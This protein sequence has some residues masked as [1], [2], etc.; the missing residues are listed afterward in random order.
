[1][2][3][4]VAVQLRRA[5]ATAVLAFAGALATSPAV[6]AQAPAGGYGT[7]ARRATA[8]PMP[9]DRP[10]EGRL[11]ASDPRFSDGSHFQ[12]WRVSARVGE[13]LI[14]S[15]HSR[16]FAAFLM[17]LAA[18]G[19]SQQ[20]LQVAMADTASDS[21]QL[22][23]HVRADGDYLLVANT[24]EAG[25][26]GR[27]RMDLRRVELG[28]FDPS[29]RGGEGGVTA[30]RELSFA[31]APLLTLGETRDGEL[32]ARDGMLADSSH[33]NVWRYDGRVG[34]R[35]VIDLASGEF[36]SYLL[37]VRA[38]E[39][40]P[41]IF[42][43]NDDGAGTQDAQIAVELPATGP[44]LI[45]ATSFRPRTT[46]RYRLTL[47]TMAD[48]CAAGG[49]C[50]TG[51]GPEREP[52]FANVLRGAASPLALGDSALARLSGSDATLGDGTP[53]KAYRLRGEAGQEI[54]IFLEARAPDAT[55]L[56]PFLHL[57][58]R[59]GDSLIVVASDDDNGGQRNALVTARLPVGGEYI[60]V[61]NGLT[62]ADTGNF[63][64][65]V[66]SLADACA[67]RAVC[68][69]GATVRAA[70]P[71]AAVRT[72]AA[73]VI[74]LGT[75]V[76]GQFDPGSAR[77][78][79]GK[80]FASWRYT[81]RSGERIVVTNR[82]TDF[83]ALVTVFAVEG[84]SVREIGRDDDGAGELNAQLALEF[85]TAG[86]YLIVA[87]S[88]EASAQGSYTLSLEPLDSACARGGPCAPGET[89][90]ATRRLLPAL[91]AT[92]R[93]LPPRGTLE[94]ALAA[95][96]P[97]L[98]GGGRFQSFRFRGRANERV[99]ITMESEG[100]DAYLH[101]AFI[102]GAGLR[103]VGSDDDG[104]VGTNARLVATLPETGEYLVIASVLEGGADTATV[105]FRI[106]R[107]TCDE[108][109]SALQDVPGSRTLA[110]FQPARRAESR[111]MP[112]DGVIEATIARG[113]PRLGD[114]TPFHAY[115]IDGRSG[116]TLRA[117]V[118]SADFDPVV[119][120]LRIERNRVVP[121]AGNDDG[122]D[123]TD[124]L[125]EWPIDRSGTYL[126]LVTAYEADSLGSYILNVAQGPATGSD[127][128]R[129]TAAAAA[130][131]PM[132]QQIAAAP[133]QP[134]ALGGSVDG[135]FVA[136]G[137]T[138]PGRGRLATFRLTGVAGQRV[139]V[140]LTADETDAYLFL[141]RRDGSAMRLLGEDDDSAGGTDARITLTLP[142]DGE[143]LI[144]ASE[145]DASNRA[146]PRRFRVTLSLDGGPG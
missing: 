35:L 111:R 5:L 65:R 141:V 49:P 66:Q 30:I 68:R 130:L 76:A 59:E 88:F 77:H 40:G 52:F 117:A 81:A 133:S 78:A 118:H 8:R 96:T 87:G 50:A 120:L 132:L 57:L 41:A 55:R 136:D 18:G 60:I 105:Q 139:A 51:A 14:I 79:D 56:D 138:L 34:E 103:L 20:P 101:L 89:S 22:T 112:A 144:V 143:Y 53:F 69:I 99:V 74:A 116:Q 72:A 95:T 64:V 93:P 123:G 12:V 98:E 16:E 84:D 39:A 33:F 140:T 126:V 135:E 43:T 23:F 67:S 48:A 3:P 125:V 63:A 102:R 6:Q 114:G 97:H 70:S 27:Y 142:A 94:G 42:R 29:L 107:A 122:G 4:L 90:A 26:T 113:A 128:F 47:R 19:E 82:S 61:A 119:V 131:R 106:A 145:Y 17:V 10:A 62:A 31:T 146:S 85:A 127:A 25:A 104:G 54:A 91:S 109:C 134:I 13:D 11:T 75:S 86:E 2:A 28:A 46:G 9:G 137:P 15:L 45:V 115:R 37:L 36:D 7:L 73:G 44:Y 124:A 32:T 71:N 80:P 24:Q 58:R 100:A 21:A 110:D 121:V 1:M 108:A 92:S 38:T 83:D 129:Q